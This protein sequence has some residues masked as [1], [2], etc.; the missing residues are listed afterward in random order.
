MFSTEWL[1][2]NVEYKEQIIYVKGFTGARKFY[3]CALWFTHFSF[4]STYHPSWHNS[5]PKFECLAQPVG[6]SVGSPQTQRL[7]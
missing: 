2:P 1:V 7:N 4:S 6:K 3:G 5:K